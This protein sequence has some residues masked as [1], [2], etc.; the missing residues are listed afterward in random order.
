MATYRLKIEPKTLMSNLI[1]RKDNYVSVVTSLNTWFGSKV[2]ADNG[3]LFNNAMANFA[4]PNESG[5]LET[6]NQLA[7]GRRPLTAN[8]VALSMDTKDMCGTRIVTGGATASSVGQVLAYPLLLQSDLRS[9]V[10]AARIDVQHS[11]IFLENLDVRGSFKAKVVS[12]FLH[13]DEVKILSIP[14]TPVN[15][16]EKTVDQPMSID[17]FRSGTGSEDSFSF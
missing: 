7:T 12:D 5:E 6:F 11:T 9:S 8:V 4:I 16:V 1:N 14:F 13:R 10:D 3:I 17:D 15:A 2:M